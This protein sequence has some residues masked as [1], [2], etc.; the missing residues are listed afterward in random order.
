MPWCVRLPL[1]LSNRTHDTQVGR[2]IG[3][4]DMDVGPKHIAGEF[5]TAVSCCCRDRP[6]EGTCES[7][8]NFCH[9]VNMLTQKDRYLVR[10]VARKSQE[11]S[12]V[13]AVG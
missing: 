11:S 4:A 6:V 1:P 13:A 10:Y 9:F 2:S 8:V 5:A 12:Q 7:N 3:N